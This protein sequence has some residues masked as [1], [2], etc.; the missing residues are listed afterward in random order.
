MRDIT[1]NGSYPVARFSAVRAH[2]IDETRAAF[3]R[4]IRE[5]EILSFGD[6]RCFAEISYAPLRNIAVSSVSLDT[7]ITARVCEAQDSTLVFTLLDG[8]IEIGMRGRRFNV[9]RNRI[10]VV[11]AGVPFSLDIPDRNR[12]IVLEFDQD[13]LSSFILE[14]TGSNCRDL[15]DLNLAADAIETRARVA[16]L[17]RLLKRELNEG[18][19]LMQ[20]AGYVSRMEDLIACSLA[21]ALPQ[22]R[23]GR[24]IRCDRS[25]VPRYIRRTLD[26]MHAHMDALPTLAILSQIAATSPRTLIRGFNRYLGLSPLAYLRDLR[27]ERAH[28][29]LCRSLPG[30]VS[31]TAIAHKWNFCHLGRFI[32]LYRKKFG[33]SPAES[34]RNRN[35]QHR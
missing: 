16:G 14:E 17:L 15:M 27:L 22:E 32:A 13:H 9:R 1:C 6:N 28:E 5:H 31:V 29:D 33:R 2:G 24:D 26:Y 20:S 8:E 11:P 23:V 7:R 35:R 30:D 4:L 19:P 18:S 25:S 3:R 34:L 10:V 21:C 12:S